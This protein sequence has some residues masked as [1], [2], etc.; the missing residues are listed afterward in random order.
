MYYP[1]GVLVFVAAQVV[2][3]A[4]RLPL[5]GFGQ[6]A[7]RVV[8]HSAGGKPKCA[9]QQQNRTFHCVFF[10]TVW[11]IVFLSH[12]CLLRARELGGLRPLTP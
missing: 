9:C 1:M 12:P 5:C 4:Q 8:E 10:S 3:V 11:T 2:M 6:V 7:R